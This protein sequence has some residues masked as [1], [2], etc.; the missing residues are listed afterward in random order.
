MWCG[1][2]WC[3]VVPDYVEIR[4]LSIVKITQI[5]LK[6]SFPQVIL[7]ISSD[8]GSISQNQSGD[9]YIYRTSK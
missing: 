7:N 5:V 1:G 3:G 2:V 9:A 8:A 4:C 6:N